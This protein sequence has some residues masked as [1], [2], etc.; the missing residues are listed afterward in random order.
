MTFRNTPLMFRT[1]YLLPAL[2]MLTAWRAEATD[3][4]Q[5][6]Q[7]GSLQAPA[8]RA[9]R[10]YDNRQAAPV[11]EAT[12]NPVPGLPAT[13]GK[14]LSTGVRFRL[15]S[16]RFSH[17]A[18]ID[19]AEL[20]KVAAPYVGNDAGEDEINHIV[21]G[22][23]AIYAH[24]GITTAR[25]VLEKQDLAGGVLQITLIEGH[26]GKIDIRGNN[27]TST[28]FVRRRIDTP[29][30]AL[31]DTNRLR[32]DLVWINR[33][34]DL[35]TAALLK[36]G[37]EVGQTDILLQVT[38]PATRSLD[39]FVDNAGVDTSGRMRL[40]VAGHYDGLLGVDDRAD[41][42][43]EKSHGGIDGQIS[44]GALVNDSNGRLS[45]SYSR[46]QIDIISGAYQALNIVGHSSVAAIQYDQP[47]IA[48][49]RWLLTGNS[50][51]SEIR[52]S[53]AISGTGVADNI[54]NA[55]S[56]GLTLNHRSDGQ[57]WTLTQN[58]SHLNST[59]PVDGQATAWTAVGNFDGV[60]RLWQSV[61]QLKFDAGWQL[62]SN[63]KL[64]SA[65][66]FQI[67][68][69]GSVRGYERGVVAGTQGYYADL[70][71]HRPLPRGFDVYAFGDH[72]AVFAAFPKER[73]ITGGG[74]GLIWH[75]KTLLSFNGDVAKSFDK[76]I[77]DQSAY[78]FDFRMAVHFE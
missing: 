64:A 77:P 2:L 29:D 21:D 51:I 39:V 63:D 48:T 11:A 7:P 1:T 3:D 18:F 27:Q 57:E 60:Q 24:R 36:P 16:V 40:G 55:A 42:S 8:Q 22:V 78:R 17:S 59:Q 23:N 33:T 76:V 67:G 49:Q 20:Q 35:N 75:Y 74:F 71:L 28:A 25:A 30:G 56:L 68:G 13:H 65:S 26:L 46:S 72:G 12:G 9:D 37:A 52:S 6:V 50:S 69:P 15:T 41:L 61:Y 45:A 5:V 70:E 14:A 53:T 62:A 38:E 31:L 34:S 44:Y 10:Y 47:F 54:T 4:P 58:V 66:L 73:N 19:D 43:I 32:D